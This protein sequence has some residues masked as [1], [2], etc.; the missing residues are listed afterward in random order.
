MQMNFIPGARG[1]MCL[2]LCLLMGARWIASAQSVKDDRTDVAELRVEVQRLALE[3]LQ[4]QAELIQWKMHWISA[5]LQQVQAERQR[6]AGERHLVEREIGDLNQASAN[7]PGAEDEGRREE[8][9]TV[10]LPALMASERAATT[11]EA[12]LAAALGAES[13]RITEVKKRMQ[14]LAAQPLGTNEVHSRE[15]K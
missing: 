12:A 15:T 7:G 10:Q 13:A 6:L 8:L 9:N 3:L 11:R 2:L 4:Y 1:C 14:R 5:E